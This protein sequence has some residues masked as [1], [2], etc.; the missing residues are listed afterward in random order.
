MPQALDLLQ[1]PPI[2]LDSQG[3]LLPL[4]ANGSAKAV[5]LILEIAALRAEPSGE[6]VHQQLGEHHLSLEVI[7]PREHGLSGR[8]HEAKG[9][10]P[11]LE[12]APHQGFEALLEGHPAA[13]AETHGLLEVG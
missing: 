12:D 13:V 7:A 3:I 11:P 4:H 5:E 8:A 10:A 1:A 2:V 9:L 6:D